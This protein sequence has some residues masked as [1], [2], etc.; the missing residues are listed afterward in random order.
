MKKELGGKQRG[1]L[2]NNYAMSIISEK[3]KGS[4]AMAFLYAVVFGGLMGYD[5][6]KET[7]VDYTFSD[8]IEWVDDAM[9][10]G[11]TFEDVVACMQDSKQ[12]KK[13]TSAAELTED[14]KKKADEK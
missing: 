13:L 12:F 4:N 2:F 11:E 3:S 5:Y 9:N 8:V 10:G 7:E 1:F 6:A 14:D